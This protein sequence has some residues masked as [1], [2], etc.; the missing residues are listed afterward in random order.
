MTKE[1]PKQPRPTTR[2]QRKAKLTPEDQTYIGNQ[3]TYKTPDNMVPLNDH[4]YA[5][6]EKIGKKKAVRAPGEQVTRVGL[7]GLK[8]IHQN[9]ID[10]HGDID[11]RSDTSGPA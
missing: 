10:Y 6:K 11:L 1:T 7:G 5:P 8:V 3:E 2:R 9:H 4:K